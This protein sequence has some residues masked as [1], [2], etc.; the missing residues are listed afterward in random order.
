MGRRGPAK[1]SL[2]VLKGKDSWRAKN[3]KPQPNATGS[4]RMPSWLS[5]EA[6]RV[7][8]RIVPKLEEMGILGAIDGEAITR[9]CL[10][11]AKW[12]EA[13]EWIQE[14]GTLF[15]VRDFVTP[16]TPDGVVVGYKEY[17][18]V[19]RTIAYAEQLLRLE[20]TFGMNPGAR[21]NLAI[22]TDTPGENRGRTKG[23]FFG[24]G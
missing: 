9:Y 23:R 16:E 21:S 10:I 17:P 14:K 8:R 7:W 5:L 3:R 22:E 12:R 1:Q 11:F 15:E 24:G 20:K 18:Q 19:K 2:T 6:K 13:E 4:P